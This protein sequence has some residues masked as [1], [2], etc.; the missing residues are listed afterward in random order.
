[1]TRTL[2]S[3][4]AA[5]GFR[6]PAEFEP[7]AGC[8]MLWPERPDNWRE[9]ARPAQLAFASV[10]AAIVQFEPV[11]VGVS[12]AHYCAARTL[13]DP[14]VRLVEMAHDD[15]WMRDVGPSC[16]INRRGV[17]RGVDWHFNAWGGLAAGLYFP[18]DQDDLV[19]RK[20]LEIEGLARYR[21]PM[22]NE[23]GA[24][25]VDG[26]GTALVTEECL[27]SANRNPGFE[28]ADVER[29]LAQAGCVQ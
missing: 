10:A 4:P 12:T 23:G 5:D 18:W 26:A 13:L 7:H 11:T 21:A 20:V 28:R 29:H 14:R 9:A 25:H 22:V 24:I 27:L 16:V 17:V 8:W 15:A 3:T 19:A 2:A 6:M 1:M